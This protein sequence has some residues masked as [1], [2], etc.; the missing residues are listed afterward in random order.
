[1]FNVDLAPLF[2]YNI[3][4]RKYWTV[5]WVN[6][7]NALQYRG[8]TLISILGS[9]LRIAVL[10]YL[11]ST[12]YQED[13]KLGT[14][15]LSDLITYY[16]LQMVIDSLVLSYVSWEI[17]DEIREGNFS[18]FL[19]RPVNYLHY[20]FMI[21]FSWK[22]FGG[23]MILLVGSVFSFTL[24]KHF[25]LPT[26]PETFL[27]FGLSLIVGGLL[28]FEFDFAIGLL[29]FWLVQANSFKYMLQYIMFFFAGTLLP[30]DLFPAAF[31]KVATLL[32]FR[33]LVFFPIQI[34]LEKE[35]HPVEGLLGA[36][37][38]VVALYF[39]LQFALRRGIARYEAVGH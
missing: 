12:I 34:F 28:A 31:H 15:S 37:V 20:W 22:L 16:L 26:R 39:L 7:Q 27:F 9:V 18:N 3:L 10:L 29:A 38:W 33:Y 32:P 8:P 25:S 6:W 23:M 14:Y 11:W 4:M 36:L 2:G 19:V 35:P 30:L 5:F 17:V 13:G 1:M 24:F 21:N